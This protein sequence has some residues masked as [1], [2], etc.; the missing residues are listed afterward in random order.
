MPLDAETIAKNQKNATIA[1]AGNID[2]IREQVA[3]SRTTFQPGDRVYADRIVKPGHGTVV[4]THSCSAFVCVTVRMDND[5][6]GDPAR[7]EASRIR[8]SNVPAPA[9]SETPQKKSRRARKSKAA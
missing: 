3:R 8:R 6:R 1:T 4:C 7:V 2:A 5:P 9:I